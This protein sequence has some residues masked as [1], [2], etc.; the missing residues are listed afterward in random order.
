MQLNWEE[1]HSVALREY[2][3]K[4]MSFAEAA[5]SLNQRFGTAYSRNAAIGRARLP[6]QGRGS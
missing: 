1:A 2:V 3:E 6:G 5:R 4:G